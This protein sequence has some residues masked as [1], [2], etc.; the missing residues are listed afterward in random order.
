MNDYSEYSNIYEQFVN[1]SLNF[2]IYNQLIYLL[3]QI[4]F[5]K[6]QNFKRQE[7]LNQARINRNQQSNQNQ[8][9]QQKRNS[10]KKLLNQKLQEINVELKALS[11]DEN[12]T[13]SDVCSS[14]SQSE[15]VNI[16]EENNIVT[17]KKLAAIERLIKH[18]QQIQVNSKNL[19]NNNNK[20]IKHTMNVYDDFDL[21]EID[22]IPI[23][24]SDISQCM[25]LL[26]KKRESIQV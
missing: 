8:I 22:H 11:I 20:C 21:L 10:K 24:Q 15:N 25:Q 26:E 7:T 23:F 16:D 4:L 17:Q 13:I 9:S 5:R 1:K 19:T 2:Q 6:Q 12:N 3:K 18:F 14:C